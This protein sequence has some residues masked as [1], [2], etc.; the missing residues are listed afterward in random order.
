MKSFQSAKSVNHWPHPACGGLEKVRKKSLAK[1][2]KRGSENRREFLFL[3]GLP[4]ASSHWS[5]MQP[6]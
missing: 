3:N 2:G 1:N 5:S 4:W 6:V